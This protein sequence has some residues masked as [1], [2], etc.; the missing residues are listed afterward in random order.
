MD[1]KQFYFSFRGRVNRSAYWLKWTL[2]AFVG[3]ILG[4]ILFTV[5]A[6][7]ANVLGLIWYV[8]WTWTGWAVVVKRYHD[9]NKSAW[10]ILIGLI[11]IIG[12]IWQVIELGFLKGTAGPNRFGPD[13]LETNEPT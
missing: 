3:L 4:G 11:P 7:V 13:P 5:D 10:W 8:L 2:P 6:F 1:P 9:R 12:S